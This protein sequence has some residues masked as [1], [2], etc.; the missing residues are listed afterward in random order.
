[1]KTKIVLLVLAFLV[2]G[3]LA[4]AD[5]R[6]L[7]KEGTKRSITLPDIPVALKDGAGKEVTG[8]LCGICH[9]LDYITTQPSFPKAKWQAEVNKMVKLYGAP[10]SEADA[11]IIADYITKSYGTE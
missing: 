7:V 10:I 3:A 1:M 8:R 5:D 11:G 9:S 6:G 2:C 4:V